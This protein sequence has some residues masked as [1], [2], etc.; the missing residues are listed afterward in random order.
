MNR[1]QPQVK[2]EHAVEIRFGYQM[3]PN[4]NLTSRRAAPRVKGAMKNRCTTLDFRS[5]HARLVVCTSPVLGLLISGILLRSR[6]A[7]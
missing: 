6:T 1:P 7:G 2:R 3:I 4:L 5:G